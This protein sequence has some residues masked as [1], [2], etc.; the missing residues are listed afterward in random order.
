M[1]DALLKIVAQ[2]FALFASLRNENQEQGYQA[3]FHSYLSKY[4]DDN[5]A[6]Q[7]GSMFSYYLSRYR[8]VKGKTH[9]K[10]LSLKAVKGLRLLE[11]LNSECEQEDKL[12]LAF[13]IMEAMDAC[14]QASV[15]EEDFLAT[16]FLSFSFD[17]ELLDSMRAFIQGNVDAFANQHQLMIISGEEELAKDDV[18]HVSREGLIGKIFVIQIEA[19]SKY[20]FRYEGDELLFLNDQKIV[21]GTYYELKKGHAISSYK[22]GFYNVKFKPLFYT[23]IVLQFVG[24]NTDDK[25]L[26]QIENLQYNFPDGGRGIHPFNFQS[27]SYLLVGVLGR[28]GSGKSTL[29]NLLTGNLPPTSGCVLLNGH[30]V[31]TE[32]KKLRGCIGYVPQDDLL[33]EELTVWENLWY[34]AKLCY[35]DTSDSELT[36]KVSQVLN[37]LDLYQIKDL[38]VGSALE[39]IISGG[40]RKRLNLALEMIREPKMLLVDEPTSGLSSN[41]SRAVMD[42]L[43][44]ITL[45][46]KLVIV[47]IHQPSSELFRQLDQLVVLD[48]GGYVVYT[49]DALEALVYFKTLSNQPNAAQKECPVC[50][51]VNP[52]KLLEII[53]EQEPRQAGRVERPRRVSP[54]KWAQHYKEKIE[55]PIEVLMPQKLS[56]ASLQ[57][58]VWRKQWQVF[59]ARNIKARLTNRG[60]GLLILLQAPLLAFM[61]AW[62]SK[63]NAGNALDPKAY[64]FSKNENIPAFLLISIIVSLFIGML[65]SAGE[66]I[67]DGRIR[68]R[69][70]FLNLSWSAYLNAKVVFLLLLMAYQ[71]ISFVWVGNTILEI[72]GMFVYYSLVLFSV[73]VFAFMLGLLLSAKMKSIV[74]IYIIIPFLII[75]QILLSGVLVKFDKLHSTFTD[76]VTPPFVADFMAS[77]WAYE[78]LAVVQF[79]E[80]EY[81]KHLYQLEQQES[82][83]SFYANYFIPG[84]LNQL[85]S[86]KNDKTMDKQK[87]W[88]FKDNIKQL[89]SSVGENEHI[90]QLLTTDINKEGF[91]FVRN[92]LLQQQYYYFRQIDEIFTHKD[93]KL[94]KLQQQGIDLNSLKARFYN[95]ALA[96]LVKNSGNSERWAAT[97]KGWI[98]TME[99]IFIAP[100]QQPAPFYSPYKRLFGLIVPT[101]YYNILMIW[102][103]NVLMYVWLLFGGKSTKGSII[104]WCKR[105]K[106]YHLYKTK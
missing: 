1:T 60:Y 14:Q 38:R 25:L 84:V 42:I 5:L 21:P 93:R 40:Q 45:Q 82:N 64:V 31:Y 37:E 11:Q 75:P 62:F 9:E 26:L 48:D 35:G 95:E 67:R 86:L 70:A 2:L 77:R 58:P 63:F 46:G 65:V 53:Q 20:F 29:M 78:A 98:R 81:Q 96:D 73:G 90:N 32:Q 94:V 51:N 17:L 7:L 4:V 76:E 43:H 103:L 10:Q 88:L 6:V 69:E 30:N 24:K 27:E 74:A 22:I 44:E 28:S 41:D 92:W 16:L 34:N 33:I 15:D 12:N 52:D 87:L 59:F 47:N 55:E 50:G 79:A 91:P 8:Q 19:F 68:K 104:G 56:G 57:V 106:H 54:E 85:S 18:M 66:I 101:K 97:Q 39:K 23:E 89:M 49:G 71:T 13:K 99:P 105:R 61:M 72:K 100:E 80:N 102:G 3:A 36:E 83:A